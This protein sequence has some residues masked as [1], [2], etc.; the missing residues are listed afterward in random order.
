MALGSSVWQINYYILTIVH[1]ISSGSCHMMVVHLGTVGNVYFSLGEVTSS[2]YER[3][4]GTGERLSMLMHHTRHMVVGHF[5]TMNCIGA[6]VDISPSCNENVNK[7]LHSD[8]S[9]L[10]FF[11]IFS[12]SVL[13][14]DDVR[15]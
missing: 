7:L 11:C 13:P 4:R 5:G 9:S 15:V 2:T 12:T 10:D 1:W 3:L 6:G 14:V 8:S